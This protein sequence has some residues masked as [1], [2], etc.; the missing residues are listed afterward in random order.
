MTE[1]RALLD[2]VSAAN[3]VPNVDALPEGTMDVRTV[4]AYVANAPIIEDSSPAAPGRAGGV[5]GRISSRMGLRRGIW[6][7]AAAFIAVLAVGAVLLLTRSATVEVGEPSPTTAV[8]APPTS[9]TQPSTPAT[10]SPPVTTPPGP[11]AIEDGAPVDAAALGVIE[12]FVD[13]YNARNEA[14]L[15]GLLADGAGAELLGRYATADLFAD[16]YT[17]DTCSEFDGLIRCRV[18][19]EDFFIDQIDLEPW[20]Q[21]WEIQVTDARIVRLDISGGYPELETAMAD[22]ESFV[23]E[24]DP[25]APPLLDSPTSWVRDPATIEA[26]RPHLVE[27]AALRSGIPPETWDTIE[28]YFITLSA[29][30]LEAFE[31]LLAPDA[32]FQQRSRFD[33]Q[34]LLHTRDQQQFTD[35]FEFQYLG[36]KTTSEPLKC[37]GSAAS[38]SCRVRNRGVLELDTGGFEDGTITFELTDGEITAINDLFSKDGPLLGNFCDAWIAENGTAGI[39]VGACTGSDLNERLDIARWLLEAFPQY[40]NGIGID[41][42]PQYLDESLLN[43]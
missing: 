20:E 26:I 28:S 29:G 39:P 18:F 23:A 35:H 14:V 9:I 13:E 36:L 42:P 21:R 30:D 25:D 3:P 12:G 37:T 11:E 15:L 10:T 5:D 24:R 41:I 16:D 7:A 31:A 19:F 34:S 17:I 43:E 32:S 40:L 27:F 22:L 33:G 6:S 2:R 8:T 38:V 4:R 1:Q